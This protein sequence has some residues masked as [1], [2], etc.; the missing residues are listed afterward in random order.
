MRIAMIPARMGSQRLKKKNLL[1]LNGIPLIRRAVRRCQ[2]AGCFDAIYV[3]S[4][5]E[6]F[7]AHAEAEGAVFHKRPEA[8]GSNDATSEDFVAEF[9]RAH[10]CER[11]FQVHSI[12]PL[13]NA[14]G[15]RDF[16]E[17]ASSGS[18]DTVLSC[19]EEQIECALDGKPVN[20]TFDQKTNSQELQPVQRIT[21]SLSAWQRDVYLD[22]YEKGSC[23]TYAGRTGFYALDRSSGIVI[24]RQE[25]LDM[26]EALLGYLGDGPEY[27]GLA[28]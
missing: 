4:E 2:A 17:Y 9:L 22:A 23:A 10:D 26:A 11:V 15:I 28:D 1:P 18:F 19:V 14:S 12:A 7:A 25:D 5:N 3:N 21:W 16:V 13:A 8:L 20:F 24:K 6:E 27:G